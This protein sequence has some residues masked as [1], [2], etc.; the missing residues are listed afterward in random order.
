MV[1]VADLVY[2]DQCLDT[3]YDEVKTIWFSEERSGVV[4]TAVV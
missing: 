1:V 2:V 4:S 3:S